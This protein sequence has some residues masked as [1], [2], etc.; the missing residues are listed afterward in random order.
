MPNVEWLTLGEFAEEIG[1]HP[2]SVRRRLREKG[3]GAFP[4]IRATRI[5][6]RWRFSLTD[7]RRE[8]GEPVTVTA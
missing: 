8:Q 4:G 7:L 5:G 2:E 3:A 6:S 1:Y